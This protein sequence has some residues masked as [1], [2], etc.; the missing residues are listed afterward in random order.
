MSYLEDNYETQVGVAA[1]A[2]RWA[3]GSGVFHM[4]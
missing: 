1:T 4:Q 2:L 3:L